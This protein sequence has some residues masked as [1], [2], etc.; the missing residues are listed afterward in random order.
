MKSAGG[1]TVTPIDLASLGHFPPQG[2]SKTP[3]GGSETSI[4]F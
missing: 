4:T 3:Q 1:G 2:G